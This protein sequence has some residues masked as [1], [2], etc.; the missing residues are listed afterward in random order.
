MGDLTFARSAAI[1]SSASSLAFLT[2]RNGSLNRSFGA[3]FA[4]IVV[5]LGGGGTSTSNRRM[6]IA[7]LLGQTIPHGLR[8]LGIFVAGIERSLVPVD[9]QKSA[10]RE[11]ERVS[12][13]AS[14]DT[15]KG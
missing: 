13:R 5:L 4:G 1:L 2:S 7:Q 12:T 15:T 3:A 9:L 14:G 11:G 8:V 10:V 6:G